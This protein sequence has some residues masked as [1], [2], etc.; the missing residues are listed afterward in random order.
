M[1][2]AVVLTEK[3]AVVAPAATVTPAG[4][5][6]AALLLNSVT[7]APPTGAGPF[8]VT[9][10]VEALSPVTLAGFNDIVESTGGLIGGGLIVNVAVC[11][12]L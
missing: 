5:V 8:R 12:P 9:V 2:T 10:P 11:K 3:V 7:A 1:P 4:T 6:A